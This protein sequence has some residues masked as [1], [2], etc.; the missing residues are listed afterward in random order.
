MNAKKKRGQRYE[1]TFNVAIDWTEAEDKRL[2]EIVKAYGQN[3]EL[4]ASFLANDPNFG[5][6]LRSPGECS[7][8]VNYHNSVF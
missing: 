7:L 3:F 5:G 4:A 6:R 2:E 8:R 1:M